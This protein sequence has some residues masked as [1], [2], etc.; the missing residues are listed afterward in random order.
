MPEPLLGESIT[1]LDGANAG[2][3]E[4]DLNGMALR[5]ATTAGAWSSGPLGSPGGAALSLRVATSF[6]LF[7][8]FA[9]DL[10]ELD[11]D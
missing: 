10:F 11:T 3:V 4:I 8:D 6:V 2:E 9:R 7:R 1:D 5:R